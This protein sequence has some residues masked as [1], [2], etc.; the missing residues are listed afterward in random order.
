MRNRLIWLWVFV[1]AVLAVA[2]PA[3]AGSTGSANLYMPQG[4]ATT[5][6]VG[7]STLR[8]SADETTAI[9]RTESRF[10]VAR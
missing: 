5:N 10:D 3:D 4:G 1:C 8:L 7:T 9:M 6:G 2:R